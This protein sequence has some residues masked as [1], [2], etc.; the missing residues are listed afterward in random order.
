MKIKLLI[1]VTDDCIPLCYLG[2]LRWSGTSRHKW[3]TCLNLLGNSLGQRYQICSYNLESGFKGQ[4]KQWLS[5]YMMR[6]YNKMVASCKLCLP[7]LDVYIIL[8]MT[9][10]YIDNRYTTQARKIGWELLSI[11]LVI[12]ALFLALEMDPRLCMSWASSLLVSSIPCLLT[13]RP[14]TSWGRT[15]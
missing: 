4:N 5:R 2:F 11:I 1:F 3:S 15:L 10:G 12:F 14:A 8:W 9:F 13:C 6:V 7:C